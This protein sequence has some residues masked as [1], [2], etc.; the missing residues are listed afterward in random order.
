MSRSELGGASVSVS[1]ALTSAVRGAV[2]QVLVVSI[3]IYQM[4]VSPL[5]GNCCRF[6]PSCSRYAQLCIERLGPLRGTWLG[7][8]R[9]LRC[10]PFC[11]G[12][13]DPPP[14]VTS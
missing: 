10:H 6:E 7:L 8:L 14:E 11:P 12:G 5:L 9:V 3:R 13:H 4:L 2:V 1:M